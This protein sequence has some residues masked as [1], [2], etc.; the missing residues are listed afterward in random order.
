MGDARAQA[1]HL[2]SWSPATIGRRGW[3]GCTEELSQPVSRPFPSCQSWNQEAWPGPR[4]LW[5]HSGALPGLMA[6]LSARWTLSKGTNHLFYTLGVSICMVTR[7]S[8]NITVKLVT[9]IS[10]N[11]TVKLRVS[12]AHMQAVHRGQRKRTVQ[13]DRAATHP[14]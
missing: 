1:F 4:L 11:I 6:L 2:R 5:A 14:R 13:K 10:L 12:L 8:L 7:L 3:V 9:R